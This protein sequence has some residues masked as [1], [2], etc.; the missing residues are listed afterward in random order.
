MP[1]SVLDSDVVEVRLAAHALGVT[2]VRVRQRLD[3]PEDVLCGPASRGRG[4]PRW[5]YSSALEAALALQIGRRTRRR[6]VRSTPWRYDVDRRLVNVERTLTARPEPAAQ[7]E[8]STLR[9]EL[10]DVRH[11]LLRVNM[12]AEALREAFK[13]EQLAQDFLLK[14]FESQ[15]AANASLRRAESL[16]E[17]AMGPFIV[18][19]EAG[20]AH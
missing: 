17:E 9:Q 19:P 5:V 15:R 13:Q 12:A 14:A 1:K 10:L 11:A 6:P 2:S 4:H 16:R 20:L 7:D 18:D 8:G 3:D